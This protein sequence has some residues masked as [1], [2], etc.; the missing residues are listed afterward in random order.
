[1]APL[2]DGR[3]RLSRLLRGR[4]G[5]EWAAS[6]H[7]IGEDF[8]LIDHAAL[9]PLD[10]PLG[11]LGAEAR[12]FAIGRQDTSEGVAARQAIVGEALRPPAPV[13]LRVERCSN[14]DIAFSWIRRSRIGWVWAG[15]S[16]T[17]LG[18]ERETYRLTVAGEGVSRSAEIDKPHFLYSLADQ[19]TD[20]ASGTI[21]LQVVQVGT[22][23]TSRAAAI[24]FDF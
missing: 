11:S 21:E 9:M 3:F 12:L 6:G 5:T 17:P 22:H 10:P 23:G 4:M 24:R 16:D 18:E 1:V 20:G 14:G 15:G 7:Q 2:G 19:I 13:H 8:L